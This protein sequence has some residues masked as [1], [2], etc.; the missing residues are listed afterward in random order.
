MAYAQPQAWYVHS[1]NG[2]TTGYYAIAQYSN[3]AWT[4]GQLVR[5]LAAQ[6]VGNERT[7][8]CTTAGTSTVE[9]TWTFTKGALQ[10]AS[11][12]TFQ[13]CSGEP[14]LNGD[15]SAANCSQ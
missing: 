1:G 9:P 2:S 6:T 5:P 8:V 12:A 11:G 4:A 7:Y 3:K 14:G 15:I 13:E 10:N